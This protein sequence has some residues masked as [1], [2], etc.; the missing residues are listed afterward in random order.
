MAEKKNQESSDKEGAPSEGF[1]KFQKAMKGHSTDVSKILNTHL[2]VEYFLEQIIISCIKRGDI[3]ITEG[4]LNFS[5]KLLLIKSFDIVSD[6]LCAS[7]KQLNTVRNRCSHSIDYVIS[8]ADIDLIG[9]PLPSYQHDKREHPAD[10]L[11]Y[12]LMTIVARL[13][14]QYETILDE[15]LEP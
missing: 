3:L 7:I 9:R 6:D 4:H 12:V 13:E 2:L 15:K 5:T 14:A 10:P 8:E 1:V 11:K